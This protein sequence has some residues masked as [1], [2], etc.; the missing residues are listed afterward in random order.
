M[1]F[2]SA[3]I[4]MAEEPEAVNDL[5]TAITDYKIKLI[6]KFAQYLKPDSFTFFDDIAT[7]RGLF[8]SP[9]TYRALI[10][11]HHKRMVDT[12]KNCGMIPIQH[13]C[14]RAED[15][16][17]DMVEIGIDAWNSVQPRN[18][19][20]GL[21]KKYGDKICIEGG[22]NTNGAPGFETATDAEIE[23]EV[24]RCIKEYGP[25]KGYIFFG[26]MMKNNANMASFFENFRPI[27]EAWMKFRDKK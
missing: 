2:E 23:A 15:I 14:G 21:L 12:I 7:E 19:I 9:A 16:I 18:D 10:K 26:F 17:E 8:I 25:Y 4:A 24:E 13:T 6:E 1:G 27:Q 22:Y 20:A 5:L 11:P 3:L